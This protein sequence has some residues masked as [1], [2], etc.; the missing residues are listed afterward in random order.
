MA[1]LHRIPRHA[2]RGPAEPPL[3]VAEEEALYLRDGRLGEQ[4]CNLKIVEGQHSIR[5]YAAHGGEIHEMYGEVLERSRPE[6]CGD[7][8]FASELEERQHL[9]DTPCFESRRGIVVN[10]HV[11]VHSMEPAQDGADLSEGYLK[12]S[13][14]GRG[15]TSGG[16]EPD[17]LTL[18]ACCCGLSV[19]ASGDICFRSKCH[20]PDRACTAARLASMVRIDGKIIR[21]GIGQVEGKIPVYRTHGLRSGLAS[22]ST[23]LDHDPNRLRSA[24]TRTAE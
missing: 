23:S 21:S 7:N 8:L 6:P 4:P 10:G 18:D 17:E 14:R 12:L 11:R 2:T 16:A 13:Y 15:P 1:T 3:A 19:A 20:G 22:T 24:P 5:I 9:W